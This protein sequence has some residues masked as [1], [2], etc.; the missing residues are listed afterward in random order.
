VND[1]EA[2]L[3]VEVE[4]ALEEYRTAM[5]KIWDLGSDP[6]M[7]TRRAIAKATQKQKSASEKFQLALN[8]L[9]DYLLTGKA[10]DDL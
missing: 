6:G 8:R 10:P 1:I 7:R 3:L 2:I 5:D 9:T 4:I